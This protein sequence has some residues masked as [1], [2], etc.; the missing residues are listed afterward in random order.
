LAAV[1]FSSVY[2]EKLLQ[3]AG[4]SFPENYWRFAAEKI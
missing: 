4:I 3:K 2:G 1:A